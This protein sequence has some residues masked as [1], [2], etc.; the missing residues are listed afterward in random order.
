MGGGKMAEGEKLVVLLGRSGTL[1]DSGE[2]KRR[3]FMF[4]GGVF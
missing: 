3:F 1:N 2:K 4:F